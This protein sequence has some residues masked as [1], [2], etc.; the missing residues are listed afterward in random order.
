MQIALLRSRGMKRDDILFLLGRGHAGVPMKGNRHVD[1]HALA[2]IW[3]PT[4]HGE[5]FAFLSCETNVTACA[6]HPKALP[7]ILPQD[8]HAEWQGSDY[9]GASALAVLYA[10]KG[11]IKRKNSE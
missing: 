5:R 3:Q 7:V 11:V 1:D 9:A 10:D 6:V 2:G 8:A 4:G